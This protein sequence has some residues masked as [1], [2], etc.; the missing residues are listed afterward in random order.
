MLRYLGP[1]LSPPSDIDPSPLSYGQTD[2]A[3]M[4]TRLANVR[5]VWGPGD[6]PWVCWQCGEAPPRILPT[7]LM[8][9]LPVQ[10]SCF[11][12]NIEYTNM[13]GVTMDLPR[14]LGHISRRELVRLVIPAVIRSHKAVVAPSSCQSKMTVIGFV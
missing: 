10:V 14:G 11:D 2:R 7:R 9:S 13:S 3:C 12:L 6:R 4:A 8:V 5:H 1:R